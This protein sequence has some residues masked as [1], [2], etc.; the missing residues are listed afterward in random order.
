MEKRFILKNVTPPAT[1]VR[2]P[3]GVPTDKALTAPELTVAQVSFYLKR[4]AQKD[5]LRLWNKHLL[6]HLN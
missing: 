4:R 2:V 3:V 5:A 1:V 6:L